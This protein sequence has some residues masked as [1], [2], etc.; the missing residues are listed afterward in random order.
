MLAA[1]WLLIAAAPGH[2]A[3]ELG[4]M[5]GSWISETGGG[6]TEESWSEPRAG[7][8]LGTGR[9]GRGGELRDWEFMRIAPDADGALAFWGSPKG[10]P[11]VPFRLVSLDATEAVFENRSH[12]YPQRIV[13][14]REGKALVATVSLADGSNAA[15]WRYRRR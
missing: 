9:S 8:M 10:A 6:W 14:R 7:M 12:D 5:S 15:S 4:W 1:A 2:G 3:A 11:A 13:Y